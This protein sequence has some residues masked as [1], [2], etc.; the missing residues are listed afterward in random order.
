[1]R[2]LIVLMSLVLALAGFLQ[3]QTDSP[4][5]ALPEK[6][7]E[8]KQSLSQDAE[9][10]LSEATILSEKGENEKAIALLEE[11]IRN[12][13]SYA[14]AYYH[15]GII[16]ANLGQYDK[17]IDNFNNAVRIKP[18][19]TSAYIN[20]GA[21]YAYLKDYNQALKYLDNALSLDKDNP[22]IYYN[23]GLILLVNKET[24]KASYFLS[25]AKELSQKN[26]DV[27]MIEK[28][29]KIENPVK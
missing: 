9:V 16:Y 7:V 6:A 28:I 5:H 11:N 3:A 17:A 10:K 14:E 18:D 8:Q 19:F 22:K 24:K 1:M 13:P 27:L 2:I 4:S 25:R 23:I 12:N 29:R 15:L 20:L 21:A 26:N